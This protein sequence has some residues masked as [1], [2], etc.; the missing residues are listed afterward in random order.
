[1]N[2][3]HIQQ[4][5]RRDG[6]AHHYDYKPTRRHFVEQSVQVC[7]RLS[8]NSTRWIVDGPTFDGRPLDSALSDNTAQRSECACNRPDECE[9]TARYAD[10]LPLPTAAELVTLI[11]AALG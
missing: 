11:N 8:D 4:S 5:T 6:N 7:L 10:Q 3:P 2:D 1:M 9:R